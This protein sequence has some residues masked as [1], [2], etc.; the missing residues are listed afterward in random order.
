[1]FVGGIYLVATASLGLWFGSLV[2]NYRKKS[3]MLG[4][5]ITSL[6]LFS[7]AFL[8]YNFTPKDAFTTI[9]SPILWAFAFILM[10]GVVVGNIIAI[11][12]P[13]LV[14]HLV[15][16]ENRDK[17]N[18][19]FGTVFGISFAIT[20]LAS[21]LILGFFGMFWVLVVAILFSTLALLSISLIKIGEKKI[22][23]TE[24]GSSRKI[25]IKGTFKV[26]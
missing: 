12:I 2:D 6:T 25:D 5:S 1:A 23:H 7:V 9:S 16:A 14:T 26:V 8:I 15:E 13:T 19:M 20:S 22:I 21:G 3:V 10:A 11:A 18:G 4:S 17:A 24:D